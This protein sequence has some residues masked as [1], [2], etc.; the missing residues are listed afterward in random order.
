M[1]KTG[2]PNIIPE[3]SF[4][5]SDS[6]LGPFFKFIKW[7]TDKK[8]FIVTD[9]VPKN[10]LVPKKTGQVPKKINPVP[11]KTAKSRFSYKNTCYGTFLS[12]N[13]KEENK[14]VKIR[15]SG[16]DSRKKLSD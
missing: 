8:Y 9:V 1:L 7:N 5:D 6:F 4:Q 14:Y 11:K 16:Y 12:T 10:C 13:Q 15:Y 3:R 2:I